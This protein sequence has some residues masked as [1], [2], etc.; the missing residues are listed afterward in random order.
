MSSITR[1]LWVGV[2]ALQLFS[3]VAFGVYQEFALRTGT[4]ITLQTTPIDPRDL[5]RGE[6]VVLRY[7][8]STLKVA[9]YE[10]GGSG[11]YCCISETA[12]IGDDVLVSLMQHADEQ[13]ASITYSDD[14]SQESDPQSKTHYVHLVDTSSLKFAKGRSEKRVIIRGKIEGIETFAFTTEYSI[15]YGV[16]N[17]FVPEGRGSEIEA[18][19]DVKVVVAVG[20]DGDSVIKN[21]IVDGEA[22]NSR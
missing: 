6:Y 19:E 21:L 17:F 13:T 14:S 18:A 8:I 1:W 16:E 9:P 20:K 5:F 22:W 11:E 12:R 2:V 15:E 7:D 10:L 3:I 4:Q